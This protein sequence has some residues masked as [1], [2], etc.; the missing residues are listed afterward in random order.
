MASSP[1]SYRRQTSDDVDDKYLFKKAEELEELKFSQ[2]ELER[3][4]DRLNN[5]SRDQT[6]HDI[7]I[8][9]LKEFHNWKFEPYDDGFDGRIAKE[10]ATRYYVNGPSSFSDRTLLARAWIT[11]FCDA[12]C[13]LGGRFTVVFPIDQYARPR[14]HEDLGDDAKPLNQSTK[15]TP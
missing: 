9:Y 2:A 8:T 11:G 1:T 4:Q 10:S 6:P 3:V 5:R 13:R 12:V 7:V 14:W 15:S